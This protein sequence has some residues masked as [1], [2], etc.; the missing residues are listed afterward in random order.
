[1]VVHSLKM[2]LVWKIEEPISKREDGLEVR[3]S[4]GTAPGDRAE[5][6]F[7]GAARNACNKQACT[8]GYSHAMCQIPASAFND[9][10]HRTANPICIGADQE[11]I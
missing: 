2:M 4:G 8:C 7:S 3:D 1:M 11:C 10:Q 9:P 6:A 5:S